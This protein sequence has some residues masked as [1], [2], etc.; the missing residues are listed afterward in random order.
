MKFVI[1][2]LFALLTACRITTQTFNTKAESNA[3]DVASLANAVDFANSVAGCEMIR[4]D[5]KVAANFTFSTDKECESTLKNNTCPGGQCEG[6]TYWSIATQPT[7][8]ARSYAVY[9]WSFAWSNND[10]SNKD[11][12]AYVTYLHEIGHAAGLDHTKR[13]G[14]IM[15]QE[16]VSDGQV[17]NFDSVERFIKQLKDNGNKCLPPKGNKNVN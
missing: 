3:L 5:D 10:V 6:I 17:Y 4:M 16:V 1:V 12:A 15:Y 11:A 9:P 13:V 14:D 7:I 2:I 8:C